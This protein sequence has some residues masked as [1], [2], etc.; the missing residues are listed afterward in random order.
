MKFEEPR[1]EFV[2]I[3]LN[4]RMVTTNSTTCTEDNY[5]GQGGTTCIGNAEHSTGGGCDDTAPLI[6]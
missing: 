6:V 2:E 5:S 3:D 1:A 4:D